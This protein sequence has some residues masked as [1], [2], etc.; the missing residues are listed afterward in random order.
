MTPEWEVQRW[1]DTDVYCI[2]HLRCPKT[3]RDFL[4]RVYGSHNAEAARCAGC[5][6][7]PPRELLVAV[8]LLNMDAKQF[9]P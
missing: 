1:R 5:H 8:D 9:Q 2:E 7:S 4:C 3:Y 6:K